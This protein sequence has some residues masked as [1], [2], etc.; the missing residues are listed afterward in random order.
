MVTNKS[1]I[2]YVLKSAIDSVSYMPIKKLSGKSLDCLH[3]D[4]YDDCKSESNYLFSVRGSSCVYFYRGGD[5][6]YCDLGCRF[7]GIDY[8]LNKIALGIK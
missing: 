7:G 8:V 4:V 2:D 1:D 3:F 6:Y 5:F